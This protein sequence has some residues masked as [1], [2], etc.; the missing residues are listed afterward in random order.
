MVST[1][2]QLH[3]TRPRRGPIATAGPGRFPDE[4]ILERV[5][6]LNAAEP[7]EANGN[8]RWLRSR[9]PEAALAGEKQST[10][11]LQTCRTQ[12]PGRP[13]THRRQ[14]RETAWPTGL[15]DRGSRRQVALAGEEKPGV[16]RPSLAKRFAR[17]RPGRSSPRSSKLSSPCPRAARRP[18]RH[19]CEIGS[20]SYAGASI[21]SSWAALRAG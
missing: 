13:K 2:R 14:R 11:G 21:G 1:L 16:R 15:A 17:A 7:R 19:F 8:I 6:V 18:R 9:I 10:L 12:N 4:E 3:D 20:Y 5:V